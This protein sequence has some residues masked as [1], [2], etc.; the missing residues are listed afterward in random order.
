MSVKALTRTNKKGPAWDDRNYIKVYQLRA[1][2]VDTKAKVASALGISTNTLSLWLT[3]DKLLTYAWEEGGKNCDANMA[4]NFKDFVYGRLHP[5]LQALWDQ[6]AN[7]DS[8]PDGF[9]QLV[10]LV[11][12]KPVQVQQRIWLY[13][14]A[15]SG[16]SR[17]QA[18]KK[19]GI[20]TKKVKK[21]IDDDPRFLE[22]VD[23]INEAKKDFFE[24]ALVKRVKARDTAAILF[25]NKT[26]NRDRGYGDKREIE[27]KGSVEVNHNLIDITKLELSLECRREIL[28][29][30]RDLQA[31]LGAPTPDGD[32]IEGQLLEYHAE[33]A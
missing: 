4:F 10:E 28:R 22:L 29:A 3:K 18:C 13:A 9:V 15:E 21:W 30:H 7:V 17:S 11:Q 26:Y 1:S 27:V 24:G 25:A 5:K 33:E 2:G 32:I 20:P 16:W 31:K 12:T 14:F 8:G 19:T 6:I 23:E